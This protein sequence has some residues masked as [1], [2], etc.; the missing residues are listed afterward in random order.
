MSRYQF[1]WRYGWWIIKYRSKL[2]IMWGEAAK[3]IHS[4]EQYFVKEFKYSID[5]RNYHNRSFELSRT[6]G[7]RLHSRRRL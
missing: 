6:K 7:N 1:S 2:K 5:K 3:I 4:K